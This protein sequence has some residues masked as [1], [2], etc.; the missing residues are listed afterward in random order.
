MTWGLQVAYDTLKHSGMLEGVIRTCVQGA[1]HGS[2]GR[3]A[4]LQAAPLTALLGPNTVF[5]VAGASRAPSRPC[6]TTRSAGHKA[7]GHTSRW[8]V[9]YMSVSGCGGTLHHVPAGLQGH[10]L[11]ML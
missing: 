4:G 6:F 11:Q 1:A 10:S 8:H 9:G 3:F 5:W 7:V 2:M